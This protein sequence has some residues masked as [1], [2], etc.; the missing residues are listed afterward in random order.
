MA[1]KTFIQKVMQWQ[2]MTAD[3]LHTEVLVDVAKYFGLKD[4]K[5]YFS[6]LL[7]KDY[8]TLDDCSKRYDMR[9]AMMTVIKTCHG[10]STYNKVIKCF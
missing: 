10:D 6:S 8:L 7:D 4:F 3:N 5:V 9:N 1:K 2:D